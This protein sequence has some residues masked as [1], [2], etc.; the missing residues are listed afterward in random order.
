MPAGVRQ[1]AAL[2]V[3]HQ[4]LG[5]VVAGHFDAHAA[6][7]VVLAQ[8]LLQR[9]GVPALQAL[10]A[11]G[12]QGDAR[13]GRGAEV[14]DVNWDGVDAA[15]HLVESLHHGALQGG[16]HL[17]PR[18][19]LGRLRGRSTDYRLL[20]LLL[21]LGEHVAELGGGLGALRQEVK[22]GEVH[23][24]WHEFG[25]G[26]AGGR[27][28]H[29]LLLDG[30]GGFD[31]GAAGTLHGGGGDD[32]GLD[33]RVVGQLQVDDLRAGCLHG[34]HWEEGGGHRLDGDLLGGQL[35]GRHGVGDHRGLNGDI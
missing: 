29:G 27:H 19:L 35:G 6:P 16:H 30:A 31:D 4:V 9:E 3:E 25:T 2:V 26:Q 18:D 14:G 28:H 20:D 17:H 5:A 22:V 33:R 8:A 13:V 23:G 24:L 1:Q 15:Q 32:R 11:A 21:R 12:R 7:V 34:R 10:V